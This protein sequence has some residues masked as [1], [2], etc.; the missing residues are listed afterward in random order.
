MYPFRKVP[1]LRSIHIMNL[2]T[3]GG[4]LRGIGRML[5]TNMNSTALTKS[6]SPINHKVISKLASEAIDAGIPLLIKY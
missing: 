2:T 4:V 6:E 5:R 1:M 3:I